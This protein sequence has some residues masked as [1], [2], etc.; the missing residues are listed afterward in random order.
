VV[1][2]PF[3]VVGVNPALTTIAPT[4]LITNTSGPFLTLQGISA[5]VTD[6]LFHYP[7]QVGSGAAAPSV[8]P[9]TISVV[10]APAAKIARCTVTNAY[11]FLD[12]EVGRAMAQDLF[13]GAFNTGVN[14]TS[15]GDHVTLRNLLSCRHTTSGVSWETMFR[16][17]LA[18]TLLVM[19]LLGANTAAA[20][21]CEGYC[22]GS[23]QKK[24]DHHHQT[25]ARLASPRH[26]SHVQRASVDCP[27]C[28]NSVGRSSLHPPR[29]GMLGQVQ[30]LQE[31]RRASFLDRGV[32]QPD[33][34]RFSTGF[35]PGPIET[36]GFLPFQS[37]PQISSFEPT[38]VALRI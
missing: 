14:I 29:C 35:W 9:Y 3:D 22:A 5:G 21:V 20:A 13:I 18:A 32:L 37:P 25:E 15:A 8:Y 30:A 10:N 38:R 34:T 7:N 31:T 6:L 19:A 36:E 2:G 4:I 17:R 33:T 16:R 27:E 24:A 26:H 11:D 1:E 28:L 23:G 12:I